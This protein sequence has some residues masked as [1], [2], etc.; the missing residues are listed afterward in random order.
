[1]TGDKKPY[2]PTV[3]NDR[4]YLIT[5][6]NGAVGMWVQ[7]RDRW[8]LLMGFSQPSTAFHIADDVMAYLHASDITGDVMAYLHSK[9]IIHR[10]WKPGNIMCSL[11]AG[12][13]R[14][15]TLMAHTVP[16]LYCNHYVPTCV[17][18]GYIIYIIVYTLSSRIVY[19]IADFGTSRTLD[20]GSEE[21]ATL[22]G[23]VE[24]LVRLAYHA[25]QAKFTVVA[26]FLSTVYI[27]CV[28]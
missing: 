28:Q 8:A 5:H 2:L 23:T 3:N 25:G 27:Q 11:D 12:S 14:Y 24:Y 16:L 26:C 20:S 6:A 9:G 18:I 19:K 10:D 7:E 13:K 1:M 15:V 22:H 17:Y 21:F 4:A